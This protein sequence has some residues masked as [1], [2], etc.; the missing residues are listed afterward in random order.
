MG[1]DTSLCNFDHHLQKHLKLGG[2]ESD[3]TGRQLIGELVKAA[4]EKPVIRQAC[5]LR[6]IAEYELRRSYAKCIIELSSN[7]CIKS[8]SSS[9]A[10]LMLAPTL[11]FLEANRFIAL[12]D[13]IKDSGNLDSAMIRESRRIWDSHTR[14]RGE[15]PFSV[16][17]EGT[18]ISE[19]QLPKIIASAKKGCVLITLFAL[20]GT[21]VF[22]LTA[23][24]IVLP[25]LKSIIL[26]H[27]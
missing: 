2:Y 6:G 18:G 15:A 25:M 13:T 9:L 16:A 12:L 10:P 7:P 3:E 11:I 1:L 22:T 8:A 21:F 27:K 17:H 14:L 19:E 5:E 23:S 24:Q 4:L 26:D 20:A